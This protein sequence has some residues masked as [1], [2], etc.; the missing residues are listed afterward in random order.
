MMKPFFEIKYLELTWYDQNT[1]TNVTESLV[2]LDVEYDENRKLFL[3]ET[4]IYPKIVGVKK[5]ILAIR[6]LN[7]K[8]DSPYVELSTGEKNYLS[9]IQ[10]PETGVIWWIVKSQWVEEQKQ[11]SSIAPNI[12]G[13]MVLI[14]QG[15]ACEVAINGSNF[16]VEELEEYLHTFKNNLWELILDETSFVQAEGKQNQVIGVSEGTI[17]CISQLVNYAER[18]LKTPKVEL[19]EIQTLKPKKTVKPVNRT[20]MELVTKTDQRFLT[21]R[22]TE[23]SYNVAENRYV[24]FVLQRCYL[25]IKQ[26]V[27]LADNKKQRFQ[28]NVDKLQVQLNSFENYVQVNRDL[29]VYDLEK[30]RE[31]TK[32][33][34][35][36][37]RLDDKLLKSDISFSLNPLCDEF[38]TKLENKTDK[39]DGFFIQ[40][41]KD[42]KW[43]KPENQSYIL[44]T[45]EKFRDLINILEVGMELQFNCNFT[46]KA[47]K[48][49]PNGRTT[50]I[51]ELL[52]I[53][54][55]KLLELPAR[56]KAKQKFL[57]ERA[58]GIELHANSWL[59][60]LSTQE[61]A[62]QEK[63]KI[64]IRN[65]IKF[66]EENQRLCNYI[67]EKIE[68]KFRFLHAL[69]KQFKSLGITPSSYF[70]NSMTFVQNPSYQGIHNGYKT[71]HDVTNLHDEN[72]L[73]SLEKI[74]E[75]GLVNMP[76]LYERWT[77]IQ[78][79]LVLKETF[80]F[81]PQGNW[82]YQL[83]DAIQT[84]Q[85]EIK[86]KLANVQAKRYINLWYEKKLPN[87][88]KP[89]F[90]LDLTWFKEHDVGNKN[91]QFQRFVLD[92]KFYDK[93]T[94]VRE[95]GVISKINELHDK[96]NYSE[97]G[98][99]PVFLIHPCQ[100]LI[101]EPIT[102]QIWGKNTFLGESDIL[103]DDVFYSHKKGAV[104]LNPINRTLYADELQRLLGMFLQYGL[105]N[106]ETMSNDDDRTLAVPICIRCGSNDI[107]P[108]KKSSHYY[109]KGKG[110]RVER[111]VKSVW[112]QCSECEQM[113][114]YNHC[115]NKSEN[116]TRLIKNGLYWSYH[117]A[118]AIEPFNMKCPSCGEWG[119]W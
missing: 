47:Y 117:S 45:T 62:E 58:I 92:A 40:I 10:D 30:I 39:E 36:K 108:I 89:D 26:I 48:K 118:R 84:N 21:S 85:E 46:H 69:I 31:R 14:L 16:N 93:A 81:V 109:H 35:W 96:K 60:P 61:L 73:V 43:F 100:N 53:H 78:I 12:A 29:V 68:P 106:S 22:A 28:H 49:N 72:I 7:K 4:T 90:I 75:I 2:P 41:W 114:I 77:L 101:E 94:F 112:M 56:K 80:R 33:P 19:R 50:V 44:S 91:K 113:Q 115:A 86:I 13:K 66:Y 82:K 20:F 6:F 24:L 54:S 59:K 67:F 76:L 57:E 74:D 11:W 107:I 116:H 63:E 87:N 55:I 38:R 97:D 23:P 3:T 88:T 110:E 17:D 102:A 111:T 70:P 8:S 5:G 119:G 37:K 18:I 27:L 51:F 65:R 71:L 83:I 25:I 104:F 99:N 1:L 95:G 98:K 103:H 64:A 15:Q 34:Y 42:E 79:L 52:T 9:P 32:I 105:E